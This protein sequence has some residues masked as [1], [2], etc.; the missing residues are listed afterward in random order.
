MVVS[1]TPAVPTPPPDIG[2]PPFGRPDLGIL[3]RTPLIDENM[4][5]KLLFIIVVR[6]GRR[7]RMQ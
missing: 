2:G 7:S 5:R 6:E 3:Q 4:L 1:M